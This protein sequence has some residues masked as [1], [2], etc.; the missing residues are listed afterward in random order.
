MREQQQPAFVLHQR[1]YTETSLLLE[2][3]TRQHG[4]VGLIAKGARRPT[5]RLRGVLKP[6][7]PLLLSWSGRGELMSL[8]GAEIEGV[9]VELIGTGLYC[10]FYL[11]ELLLRL[12]QRLDAHERL[13]DRYRAALDGLRVS[14]SEAVL[15]VFEKHLLGEVGYGLLLEHEAGSHDPIDPNAVYDYILERGP[16]RVHHPEL[17][18]RVQGVRIRGASLLALAGEQLDDAVALRETKAL[19]RAA[20]APHLGD[21]PLQSRRLFGER[22]PALVQEE[23]A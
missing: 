14:P 10:G 21:K 23:S 6:F 7:Q 20:L 11:N 4:R 15:R 9:G 12:L 1:N 8:T 16:M 13:Y 3:Y 2:V 19:M 17:L 18:S 22:T 5:S